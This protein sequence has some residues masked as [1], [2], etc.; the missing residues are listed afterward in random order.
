MNTQELECT[1]RREQD[2]FRPGSISLERPSGMLDESAGATWTSDEVA[3]A[4]AKRNPRRGCHFGRRVGES[5]LLICSQSDGTPSMDC[6][7]T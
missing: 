5:L 4:F 6:Q 1:V 7:R 3:L 2:L